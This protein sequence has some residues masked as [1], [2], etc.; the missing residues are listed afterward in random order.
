M[1]IKCCICEKKDARLTMSTH[2]KTGML[3]EF[4]EGTCGDEKCLRQYNEGFE[5]GYELAMLDIEEA[6]YEEQ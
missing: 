5:L 4:V 1:S 3:M 2:W 6:Y